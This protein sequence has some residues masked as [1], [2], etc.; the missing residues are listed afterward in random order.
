MKRKLLMLARV[1]SVPK[2]W[3]LLESR[4]MSLL[5]TKAANFPS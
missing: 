3:F 5:V 4:E 2:P 1:A